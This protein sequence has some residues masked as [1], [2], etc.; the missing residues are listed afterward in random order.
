MAKRRNHSFRHIVESVYGSAWAILP[1]K[2]EEILALVDRRLQGPASAEELAAYGLGDD[3]EDD[4][5]YRVTSGGVAVIPVAGTIS[6]KANLFIRAS[7]GVSTELLGQTFEQALADPS[8]KAIVFDVDSPGGKVPGTPELASK[9]LAARGQ[10]PMV[11][12]A[13]S[14]MASGAYWLGSAADEVVGGPSAMVGSV[15]IYW[16]H[17]ETSRADAVAGVSRRII[18]AGKWKTLGNSIEPLTEEARGRL[19]SWIETGYSMFA[20]AVAK[21]RGTTPDRVRSSYGEGDV[22][23]ARDALAE[24]LIDRV[25][26]LDEV[27]AELEK[28]VNK[29]SAG[30]TSASIESR[31]QGAGAAVASHP[32]PRIPC[33]LTKGGN[34][35][36]PRIIAALFAK[37]LIDTQDE[38][39]AQVALRAFYSAKGETVPTGDGAE[40]KILATLSSQAAAATTATIAATAETLKP[41]EDMITQAAEAAALR[42]QK[43]EEHRRR[44]VSVACELAGLSADETKEVVAMGTSYDEAIPEIKKRQVAS[45]SPI[46]RLDFSGGRAEVEKFSALAQEAF[47]ARCLARASDNWAPK[48]FDAVKPEAR[49]FLGMRAIDL[50]ARCLHV[51]G[52]RVEGMSPRE[53]A[54]LALSGSPMGAMA[55]G[56][57]PAYYTT[58]SFANLTLNSAR[59]VLMRAYQEAPVTYRAWVRQGEPVADFKVHSLV[60]FGEASDLEIKPEGRKPSDD[61]GISDDREYFQV[62]TYAKIAHA[63][64]EMLVNDDLSAWSRLPQMQGTAAA[65]TWNKL[66]YKTLAS[67]PV[68]ADGFA[69]FDAT[70]HQ[71]NLLSGVVETPSVASLNKIQTVLRTVSGLNAD[72]TLN[73][74]LRW[75]IVPAALEATSLTLCASI[76][77]PSV[78]NANVPNIFKG[79]IDP[80]VESLLDG[81]STAYFYGAA[82][83]ANIDTFEMRFLQ[84]EESPLLE[85]WWDPETDSRKYKVRQTGAVVVADYRGL[86]RDNGA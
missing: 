83:S 46:P 60:K 43:A 15:G 82:D 64:L 9:I 52:V 72:S 69:L 76:T 39:Q 27:I 66:V 10:K 80:I 2:L 30:G 20:E 28:R 33:S 47:D 79:R 44:T 61:T 19:Q 48:A 35:M 17:V 45:H 65:R 59:K 85:D 57:G 58:G 62:E 26:T 86:V 68:M 14:L 67:N 42:M 6:Q 8:V 3:E 7:G 51:Q 12:V 32:A 18:S 37:G 49:A 21:H 40:P 25:S 38:A 53:I 78:T 73:I 74:P 71:G 63:T 34:A 4:S 24:G 23:Y 75:L 29:S 84:G 81:Y 22:L 54:K 50:A 5:G 13:N 70:N 55:M 77:D 16:I 36:N 41:T 31:G 56:G 1:G 11:A